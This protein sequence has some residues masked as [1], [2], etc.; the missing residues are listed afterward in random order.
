MP[1]AHHQ[2]SGSTSTEQYRDSASG[3]CPTPSALSPCTQWQRMCCRP[4]AVFTE[5]QMESLSKRRYFAK[6]CTFFPLYLSIILKYSVPSTSSHLM[7]RIKFP[8]LLAVQ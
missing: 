8:R 6:H 1:Y 2:W 4:P 7:D 5:K 3:F